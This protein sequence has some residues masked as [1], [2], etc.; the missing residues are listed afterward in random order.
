MANKAA[1]GSSCDLQQDGSFLKLVI[2]SIPTKT[3]LFD[4]NNNTVSYAKRRK[5]KK[6][7]GVRRSFPA[8]QVAGHR[9]ADEIERL[10]EFIENRPPQTVGSMS[11]SAAGSLDRKSAEKADQKSVKE[12]FKAAVETEAEPAN[13]Q[14]QADETFVERPE[15]TSTEFPAE[16]AEV[17][18]E[19]AVEAS[20]S[21]A[22]KPSY[23][24]PGCR[25]GRGGIGANRRTNLTHCFGSSFAGNSRCPGY[26]YAPGGA[27][28]YYNR[29]KQQF[30]HQPQRGCFQQQQFVRRQE[31]VNSYQHRQHQRPQ[32]QMYCNNR[33]F[34]Q[35]VSPEQH[36]QRLWELARTNRLLH[37]DLVRASRGDSHRQLLGFLSSLAKEAPSR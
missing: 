5:E 37:R 30:H 28:N 36:G 19:A 29:Q 31:F 26:G 11:R 3:L 7:A 1:S 24:G 10:L 4:A 13:E 23:A 32:W 15:E 17:N 18:A 27:Y 21:G 22:D 33:R 8:N 6:E 14:L 20:D 16:P 9:G 34:Q 25:G 2:S 35:A 12:E